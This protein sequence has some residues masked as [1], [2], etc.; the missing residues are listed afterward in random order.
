MAA[1]FCKIREKAAGDLGRNGVPG[2]QVG[3][4]DTFLGILI[5][6][7]NPVCQHV[8]FPAIAL[9]R[10]GNGSFVPGHKQCHDLLVT[11]LSIPPFL[12][13]LTLTDRFFFEKV[14]DF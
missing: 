5:V 14:T 4:V 1:Y 9:V 6:F 10:G 8:K 7:Q 3:V 13:P 11:H 12:C 2:L